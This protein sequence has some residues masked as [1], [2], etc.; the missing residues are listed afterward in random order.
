MAQKFPN[1]SKWTMNPDIDNELSNKFWSNPAITDSQKTTF[2]KFRTGQYMGNARKQLFFGIQRFPSITCPICSSPDVDTW[3][4]VL[5]KCNQHHIHALRI[6]RH[7]KAIWE[8]RK[9]ILS[10]QKSRCYILMNARTFNNNPQENTVP[11]WLL[12]CI[13]VQQRCHCNARLKPD[14]L[15]IKGLPYQSPSPS[16]PTYHL[17]IQFIEFTYTNDRFSQDTINNKVQPLIDKIR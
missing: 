7:N 17:T 4:H 16:S 8:I 9:L 6:K 12:S 15:C 3:L 11:P 13:C 14:I 2:L 5:L 1:I 10:A